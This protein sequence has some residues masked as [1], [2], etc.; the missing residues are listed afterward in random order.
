MGSRQLAN[1]GGQ[2][3]PGVL[4]GAGDTGPGLGAAPHRA[5]AEAGERRPGL[6]KA[7]RLRL[8]ARSCHRPP[9]GARRHGAAGPPP[10]GGAGRAAAGRGRCDPPARRLTTGRREGRARSGSERRSCGTSRKMAAPLDMEPSVLSLELL[11]TDPLLLILS[12]LDY[13][14]LMS[15][16]CLSRRLNQLSSHDPLWKRHCKKYW[17]ISEEEKSQRNQSW[18]AIF[19]STYSDLGRYIRYYATLK[20][21]WD[22]LEKYLGQRCPRMISSLKESVREEDL[23]AVEAQI[24]CKLPDDYRCSFRIHNGQKLV[25]PGLMGSMALSNHYRSEDLLDIDTAAGGFQQRLGLKQCLPLTFC[26]HT[27]LSQ[28]MALESV[29]GRNKYEIFYQCPDQMAR[30][31]SAID[32]FITGTSYLEW[33][34]SYVNKVVTGGYPIIRDQIFRYVHDKECVATTGDITVSVSTSF[35]PELSSVHPPHYFFTYRI[36]IEMSKD[37]LPEKACQLDSRYWRITNAKGDVE[38]VQG[39]GVVGEFPI[40]SPGRVYE[41]TSC[42]TFST[43][44]GYMEGYYTFHCLYYKEKFFNVTIPRFHMVCPTFKV[45]TARMETNH[46]EY[47]VDEDEDSTDTD[48]YEDRRRVLDIPAPSGRCPRHT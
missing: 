48:E 38:E 42:T 43:T 30:N 1:R 34:T 14:D 28:Y 9:A 23:D 2:R 25:V 11:P 13:R 33:F 32:M 21:A 12:F 45:S 41:Y 24:G 47:A 27:G 15:C 17:L 20:K 37:A 29:E 7:R 31:P 10:A 18:K 44:S 4:G 39:P 35:L 40:I 3:P 22:D 8:T 36:R 46:N 6:P 26:I 5:A 16:C 19:I